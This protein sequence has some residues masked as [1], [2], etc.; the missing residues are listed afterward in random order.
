MLPDK[1]ETRKIDEKIQQDNK[2]TSTKTLV[3][4]QEYEDIVDIFT[5]KQ[6]A[7]E[8]TVAS[9]SNILRK[10][11][12]TKE[13][14]FITKKVGLWRE[15]GKVY[16]AWLGKKESAPDIFCEKASC[17]YLINVFDLG[18]ELKNISFFPGLEDVILVSSGRTI[19]AVEIEE[20]PDKRIQQLY[21]GENPDFR[22]INDVIYIKD[23]RDVFEVVLD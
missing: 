13:S 14:P 12:G 20:N 16:V 4:N 23:G 11:L 17:K 5:E 9:S 8:N 1:I 2:S 15:D 7:I 3:K 10:E 21:V 19:F 18:N 6:E 22:I